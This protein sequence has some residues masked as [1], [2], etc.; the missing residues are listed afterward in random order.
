MLLLTHGATNEMAF[1]CTNAQAA[2]TDTIGTGGILIVAPRA[3]AVARA[4]TIS[5]LRSIYASN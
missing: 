1:G 5:P 4:P 3:R 2:G